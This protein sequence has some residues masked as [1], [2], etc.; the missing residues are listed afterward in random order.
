VYAEPDPPVD[1]VDPPLEDALALSSYPPTT[2]V[3]IVSPR[4]G[5]KMELVCAVAAIG[6][7][8]SGLV[9]RIGPGIVSTSCAQRRWIKAKATATTH[10][11]FMV[12]INRP[13]FLVIM[14]HSDTSVMTDKLGVVHLRISRLNR[15]LREMSKL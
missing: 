1:D 8:F 2:P 7:P 6:V 4:G 13:V 15:I 14:A 10:T 11:I 5:L 12:H 9:S 3:D